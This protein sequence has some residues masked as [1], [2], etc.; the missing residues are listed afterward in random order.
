VT[1]DDTGDKLVEGWEE[2]LAFYHEHRDLVR[3]LAQKHV[4][5]AD[6]A[7]DVAST[8][9]NALLL[10]FDAFM[11]KAKDK[12]DPTYPV[13]A[14]VNIVRCR[15]VDWFRSGRR[16]WCLGEDGLNDYR[17]VLL[18]D[19]LADRLGITV[20]MKVDVERALA[21]LESRE[22]RVLLHHTVDQLAPEIAMAHLN[23]SRSTYF[24]DL[25]SAIAKLRSSP[26]LDGYWYPRRQKEG[27]K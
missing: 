18:R 5:D 17:V 4:P 15:A 23:I 9:L 8:A 27:M 6:A 21:G 10:N 19:H 3:R 22:R 16:E 20:D 14:L 13:S 26:H 2:R 24:R 7:E 12:G 1:S 11:A 25:S